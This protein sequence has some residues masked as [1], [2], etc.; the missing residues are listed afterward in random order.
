MH[1][2]DTIAAIATPVGAGGI[3]II[4]VSGSQAL[5]IVKNFFKFKSEPV[6]HKAVFGKIKEQG[7]DEIIDSGLV[8]YLKNPHSYTGED[9]IE[10]NCHGNPYILNRVLEL[11]IKYGAR[12]A[13]AGE[14]TKR[15]FL[16]GKIDLTQAEAVYDLINSKT[17]VSLRN[18]NS[19]MEG[20][21]SGRIKKLRNELIRALSHIEAI[22][23]F[24]DEIDDVPLVN[25]LPLVKDSYDLINQLI[26]T[27]E[28]GKLYREGVKLAIV[29]QPNVGKSSLLNAL[30]RYERAIVTDIPGTTRDTL[31]EYINVRG[32]PIQVVDTAGLRE[33]QDKVEKI[34]IERSFESIN[35]AQLVL[36][37]IDG[38]KNLTEEELELLNKLE[39]TKQYILIINK[40]DLSDNINLPKNIKN[41]CFVSAMYSR[42][43]EK[44]EDKIAEIL[45][46][47][48][49][50]TSFDIN[51]NNRHKEILYRASES[52]EKALVTIEDG[53]PVDFLAIDLKSAIV[54][55]GEIIGE[56]VTEEVITEI[57]ANFCV[58]K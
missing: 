47:G 49:T 11:C 41:I 22:I 39:D 42:G 48:K 21:L 24:P 14:F 58:G 50:D 4:R 53:L 17:S 7:S 36:F 56:N 2:A 12:L 30:V 51:I 25:F 45:L 23:D 31:E 18:A 29:G 10:L 27:A 52:L 9:T 20:K 8:L 37:V 6:S 28:A 34:G 44:L 5:D 55:M 13:T 35:Q 33:T 46:S 3:G 32:I 54:S 26:D 16:N 15:A 19:Q 38:S 43:I 57:F 40:I 1:D